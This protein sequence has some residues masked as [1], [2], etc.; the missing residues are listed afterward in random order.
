MCGRTHHP[1]S[2]RDGTFTS[3]F[4]RHNPGP[5]GDQHARSQLQAQTRV[6]GGTWEEG[7]V[8]A[9]ASGQVPHAQ[10][11]RD[12]G[13]GAGVCDVIRG[14]VTRS[15]EGLGVASGEGRREEGRR[16]CPSGGV[17][18]WEAVVTGDRGGLWPGRPC[19]TDR[20]RSLLLTEEARVTGFHRGRFSGSEFRL[21][22]ER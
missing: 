22:Q 10:W 2:H 21:S 15:R 20:Q 8:S 3:P 6:G 4:H 17:L 19:W 1:P 14:G 9:S 11:P 18:C 13:K 16:G 12:R 5:R 7:A